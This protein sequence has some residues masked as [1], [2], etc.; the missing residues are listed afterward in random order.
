MAIYEKV[1]LTYVFTIPPP[2]SPLLVALWWGGGIFLAWPIAA[3]VS[4]HIHTPER[5]RTWNLHELTLTGFP[6]HVFG[7]GKYIYCVYGG[8]Y[9]C[10]LVLQV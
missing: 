7:W 10:I 5:Y 6:C 1:A 4:T 3:C 9:T 2:P 8:I